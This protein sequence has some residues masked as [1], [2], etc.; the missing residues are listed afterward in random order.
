MTLSE[1]DRTRLRACS[2]I[3]TN[4]RR[5]LEWAVTLP[6]ETLGQDLMREAEQ[7]LA[8]APVPGEHGIIR[9]TNYLPSVVQ[10]VGQRSVLLFPRIA[11]KL[12]RVSG[13]HHRM[14]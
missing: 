5:E 7:A 10:F 8:G 11:R 6:V 9:I 12:L 3:I 13:L 4:N 2:A 1:I 14:F